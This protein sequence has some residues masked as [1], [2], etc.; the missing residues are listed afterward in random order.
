MTLVW[1][2]LKQLKDCGTFK[3]TLEVVKEVNT[4]RSKKGFNPFGF[5]NLIL[6]FLQKKLIETNNL[7][8]S[9]LAGQ[10]IRRIVESHSEYGKRIEL[11]KTSDNRFMQPDITLFDKWGIKELY[12][13]KVVE[14]GDINFFLAKDGKKDDEMECKKGDFYRLLKI[15]QAFPEIKTYG[16]IVSIPYKNDSLP[17]S[18]QIPESCGGGCIKVREHIRK[19]DCFT[20]LDYF[21]FDL[22]EIC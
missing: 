20:F 11:F 13:I 18:L 21:R 5:E 4:Y 19:R 8:F 7:N 9:F 16:I 1:E 3:E 10:S 15:K 12:E 14:N 2:T 6:L 17:E 22:L